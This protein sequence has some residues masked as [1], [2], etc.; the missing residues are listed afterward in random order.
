MYPFRERAGYVPRS[1]K[2]YL[3]RMMVA[4]PAARSRSI[5]SRAESIAYEASSSRARISS[6]R[7]PP[8]GLQLRRMGAT[9]AGIALDAHSG[10]E[11]GSDTRPAGMG[12]TRVR[13]VRHGRDSDA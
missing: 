10:H 4:R 9:A 8:L 13:P 7:S 6:P 2:P 1:A 3:V 11:H 5:R 12:D